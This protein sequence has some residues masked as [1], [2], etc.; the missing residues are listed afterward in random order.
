MFLPEQQIL[1]NSDQGTALLLL[2]WK[3]MFDPYT[4]DTFQPRL[5]NLPALVEELRDLASRTRNDE[6]WQPHQKA[7][8]AEIAAALDDDRLFVERMPFFAWACAQLAKSQDSAAIERSCK[9]LEDYRLVYEAEVCHEVERCAAGLPHAKEA[10]LDALRRVA[11]MALNRGH[12]EQE[13]ERSC[14][15]AAFGLAPTEWA[16]RLIQQ[17]EASAKG[18][19]ERDCIIPVFGSGHKVL[20]KILEPSGKFQVITRSSLPFEPEDG[21]HSAVFVKLSNQRGGSETEIARL[22][23]RA[24]RP[25]LDIFGFYERIHVTMADMAWVGAGQQGNLV[26]T[27]GES[28]RRLPPRK[29]SSIRLTRDALEIPNDLLNHR[30]LNALEHYTLAQSNSAFRVKLVNLWSALECLCPSEIPGNVFERVR[31]TVTPI[32]VWRRIDKITR[33]VASTLTKYRQSGHTPGLG[34][35]FMVDGVVTAEEVLL[36][37]SRPKDH[38]HIAGLLAGTAKHP[39]LTNRIFQLWKRFSQPGVLLKDMVVSQQRT[40]W[41]LLRIYRARNLIVHEGHEIPTT[42]Y[43]VDNLQYYFS[44]TLSRILH[45]MAMR[46]GSEVEDSATHWQNR[47]AY[48]LDMLKAAP[49]ALKVKDFFPVTVRCVHDQPW[50]SPPAPAAPA[51]PAAAPAP[52]P[53]TPAPTATAP[54]QGAES[55]SGD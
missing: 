53:A 42:P 37:L 12:S 49:A 48:V 34:P 47:S 50:P 18:G 15:S 14:D 38:P 9:S 31:N 29:H 2:S 46:P 6:R 23:A 4:P 7:V 45:G 35:A 40:N 41:H 36:C 27:V 13:A 16:R 8:Q 10:A 54:S 3:E 33:Y 51:A 28:L 20:K 52:A 19:L 39:L 17:V 11:T 44:V 1:Q 22:A 24:L 30:V 26:S 5:Y 21:L 25:V 43:L 32:V 55:P